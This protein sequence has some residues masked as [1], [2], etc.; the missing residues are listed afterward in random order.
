MFRRHIIAFSVLGVLLVGAYAGYVFLNK[1]AILGMIQEQIEKT[2][3]QK[4]HLGNLRLSLFP[5]LRAEVD[6][7]VFYR[8]NVPFVQVKTLKLDLDFDTLKQKRLVIDTIEIDGPSLSLPDKGMQDKPLQEE[9][10]AGSGPPDLS[11]LRFLKTIKVRNGSIAYGPHYRIDNIRV[12]AVVSPE[13]IRIENASASLA[14]GELIA[15][16]SGEFLPKEDHLSLRIASKSDHVAALMKYAGIEPDN[17]G[18]AC[19]TLSLAVAVEA[20]R[21]K[22][23]LKKAKIAFDDIHVDA[24]GVVK[25]YN[26]SRMAFRT[27]VDTVDLNRYLHESDVSGEST[28]AE[29]NTTA[30]TNASLQLIDRLTAFAERVK[31]INS[32]KIGKLLYRKYTLED[33]FFESKIAGGIIDIDPVSL[34]MYG[35]RFDGRLHADMRGGYPLIKGEYNIRNADIVEVFRQKEVPPLLEGRVSLVGR[36]KTFGLTDEALMK[37]LNIDIALYGENLLFKK[38]DLD[39]ILDG[40][41]KVTSFDLVDFAGIVAG[42]LGMTLVNSYDALAVDETIRRG[43]QTRIV[44]M[45]AAWKI[46]DGIAS[47]RDVAFKTPKNRIAV[48]GE[49][50]L[51]KRRLKWM[52]VAVLNRRGC[53]TFEQKLQGT[54]DGEV[55]LDNKIGIVAAPFSKLFENR[56]D[57]P[58]FYNGK[59]TP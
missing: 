10:N 7:L 46:R 32:V 34:R 3:R 26:L 19:R 35:G 1:Q 2:T 12:D 23:V 51:G 36:M 52:T 59:I 17:C 33:I 27:N 57:C 21:D 54:S 24:E 40:L 14:D 37:N 9:R 48:K 11:P 39:A 30:E 47:A 44:K 31:I 38:Y 55:D 22:L 28:P 56:Y 8:D 20:F 43:G 58:V 6:D 18:D 16:I 13:R 45:I 50:D 49:I 42:P 29:T 5:S 4:V 53:A 41:D 15:A 25:D